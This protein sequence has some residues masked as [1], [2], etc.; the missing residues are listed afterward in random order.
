MKTYAV[1]LALALP[2]GLAAQQPAAPPQANPI[3]T[4]F[5][6]RT[7]A[8]QRNLAQAFDSIPERLFTYRP[9][10]SQLTIGYIAQHLASDN[11]FFCNNFGD[12][13]AP[14]AAMDTSTADSVKATWPKQRLI[15]N[16]NASFT[17]CENA[18]G[19]LDDA[20]LADQITLT[21]RGQS[22]P[23]TRAS[24]VLGHTLDMADHYSQLANYMRLNNMIPPTALPRPAR[25][26]P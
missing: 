12:M 25:P 13:K 24:M 18:L 17:F 26:T 19:Q 11:Y 10:P 14:P 16:L 6:T 4:V 1:L 2:A 21:F 5:R 22:R 15:A 8:L 23:A 9:T 20:K 3:T 7:L